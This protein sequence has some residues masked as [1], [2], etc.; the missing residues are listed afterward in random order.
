M[1]MS[2]S[3]GDSYDDGSDETLHILPESTPRLWM[4]QTPATTKTFFFLYDGRTSR[5][6]YEETLDDWNDITELK[7]AKEG[8]ALTQ[9]LDG[10]ASSIQ[11]FFRSNTPIMAYATY[12]MLLANTDL[13]E[14][15][16]HKTQTKHQT[17]WDRIA[18]K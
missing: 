10:A 1:A 12:F 9:L 7:L 18:D 14:R 3:Y 16:L 17:F 2:A 6:Q 11:E 4:T 5:F 13:K 8:L 15:S